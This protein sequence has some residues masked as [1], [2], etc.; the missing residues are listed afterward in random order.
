MGTPMKQV[1]TPVECRRMRVFLS[2]VAKAKPSQVGEVMKA[3]NKYGQDY[4]MNV[5]LFRD[6]E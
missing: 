2:L 1:L 4:L 5:V 6:G 3:W